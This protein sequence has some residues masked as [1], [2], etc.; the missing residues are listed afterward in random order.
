MKNHYQTLG[1][2]RGASNDDIKSAY[3]KLAL[4][5]H[6]DKNNGDKF[7]EERFKEIQE[8]YEILSDP[9]EKRKYDTN[10]DYFFNGQTNSNWSQTR[11]EEPKYEKPK[12]DPEQARKEKEAREKRDKE[13]AE[14]ERVANIKKNTE[15][16]FED[17]AWIF[18]GNWFIIPGAV[19]L[20]MFFKYR[21]EGY[22]KKSNSVCS[23]SLISFLVL[24]VL[25]IIITIAQSGSRY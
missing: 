18:L 12:P 14:K 23:L 2:K 24:F 25:A 11:R 15:L 8:A 9:Y 1:I 10:Y 17:K 4:K 21:S 13:R 16:S 6:P 22:T 7:F 5:F 3:R 19:G 20:W